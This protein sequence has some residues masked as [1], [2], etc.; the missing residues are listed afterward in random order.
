M[1]NTAVWKSSSNISSD[2]SME[3]LLLPSAVSSLR[4]VQ[5]GIK[6]WDAGCMRLVKFSNS[7]IVQS[8]TT[9]F[10]MTRS[11]LGGWHSQLLSVLVTLWLH[12]CIVG[13]MAFS[14]VTRTKAGSCKLE[15]RPYILCNVFYCVYHVVICLYKLTAQKRYL[16]NLQCLYHVWSHAFRFLLELSNQCI[17]PCTNSVSDVMMTRL[18]PFT[19]RFLFYSSGQF[20]KSDVVNLRCVDQLN[21]QC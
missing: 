3:N 1:Q 10:S 2:K 20:C 21:K 4:F 9:Y 19:P 6:T 7:H 15:T 18:T 11:L 14:S 5:T 17:A 16:T 13:L 8:V 12:V